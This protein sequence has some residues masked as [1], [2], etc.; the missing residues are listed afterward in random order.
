MSA[1]LINRATQAVELARNA[2]A[3]DAW[4]T[5]SQGRDV[6]F[7]YRDGKLEKVKDTTSRN[8]AI[9]VYAAGRYS[10]SPSIEREMISRC[11]S[12]VPS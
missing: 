9:K 11:I 10:R 4:A 5:A 6:V 1:D 2:G 7:E 8:L 12:D 3:Q